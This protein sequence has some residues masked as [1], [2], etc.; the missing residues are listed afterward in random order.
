MECNNR[1]TSCDQSQY[2]AVIDY[3]YSQN[4][5]SRSI[6]DR[7]FRWQDVVKESIYLYDE[8]TVSG[9]LEAN[10]YLS[11]H[12]VTNFTGVNYITSS[13]TGM[14]SGSY[15]GWVVSG[16]Y[17]LWIGTSGVIVNSGELS[18]LTGSFVANPIQGNESIGLYSHTSSPSL[19]S[20]LIG[21]GEGLILPDNNHQVYLL[22]K[23]A[24]STTSGE[25]IK[26][27][28][29]GWSAGQIV[30]YYNEV[31]G[32]WDVTPPS[33]TY[34]VPKAGYTEIIYNFIPTDF[35][36]TVPT[37]YD[38]FIQLASR[39][40]CVVVDDIHIDAILK[41]NAFVDSI[42][43][44]GYVI[45][46]TPDL[47]WHNTLEMFNSNESNIN[48]FLK[49]L[50]P[51]SI[52]AGNLVDNLDNTVTAT[53]DES[54]F[55]SA[56]NN[57]FSN[58]LWRAIALDNLGNYGK[59]SLPQRFKYIGNDLDSKFSVTSVSD[60]PSTPIKT[61]I[62]T[63]SSTSTI[64]IND[65]A[66]H[67]GLSYPTATTWK[68]LYT[69]TNPVEVI[70][71]KATDLGQA[72]SFTKYIELKIITFEQNEKALWNVFD[73]HGLLMDIERLPSESNAD[74]ASRIKNVMVDRGGAT[75]IGVMNGGVREL[76][77]D[78]IT[79][80]LS[81]K[82]A[83][84]VNGIPKTKDLL[85]DVGSADL[86]I[87]TS[88]MIIEETL[89]VDPVYH[90]ITLSKYPYDF[91]EYCELD[92]GKPI[93][94]TDLAWDSLNEEYGTDIKL[95]ISDTET[96]GKYV[97]IRYQY[98][99][100]L[101]FK[102]HTTI[103]SLI[104]AL[105]QYSYVSASMS[106]KLSGNEDS[107]GLFITSGTI[108]GTGVV[109]VTWSPMYLKRISDRQFREYNKDQETYRRSKF[110][111]Y[112]TALQLDSKVLWGSVETDR[113]YWDA[114]DSSDLSFDIIPTLMDPDITEFYTYISGSKI[115]LD[116]TQTWGRSYVGFSGEE[117]QN[118][119]LKNYYFQPGVGF[120]NDLIPGVHY[121][122]TYKYS[123][124]EEYLG[125]SELKKDNNTVLFSGQR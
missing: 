40:G 104:S 75:F 106:S 116:G 8:A 84:D 55:D 119:G 96:H 20:S 34:F 102:Q 47:G 73:E 2:P 29:R 97:T 21:T 63:K 70:A 49:V 17:S 112:V 16:Q 101:L 53:A 98:Y 33:T 89:L 24:Y 59:S 26:V 111:K 124:T 31:S 85:V 56:V 19:F 39:S 57:R 77:L 66:S 79:D 105:A 58:Y 54:E 114:A 36:A 103:G 113:D 61:I 110:Y 38:L 71:V 37:H 5:A 28:P 109:N 35:P 87:R 25:Y 18:G 100:R 107:I 90:T 108:D 10:N 22:A 123:T 50:G 43:P 82:I 42:V 4:T 118:A 72:T 68:L 52:S 95:K 45:E 23:S 6:H 9:S 48:P 83:L 13:L 44:S 91:P 121:T 120:K 65:V 115:K 86:K 12:S 32:S 93:K 64:L 62:G 80:G 60:N 117:M 46:L 27:Y 99:E 1:F 74:Y 3:D 76:G 51:F 14:D 7:S 92:N 122:S 94:L 81:I 30:A 78:K 11:L 67:P 125:I 88:E 69:L 41:K 15:P